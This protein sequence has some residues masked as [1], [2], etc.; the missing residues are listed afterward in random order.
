MD[1]SKAILF[2]TL[3]GAGDLHDNLLEIDFIVVFNG[4]K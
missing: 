3:K 1:E 2:D 4:S